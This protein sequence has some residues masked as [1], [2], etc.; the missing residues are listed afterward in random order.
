[1]I[2]FA[3]PTS[4]HDL[5]NDSPILNIFFILVWG[6]YYCATTPKFVIVFHRFNGRGCCFSLYETTKKHIN[7][8]N[9]FVQTTFHSECEV[10]D[11]DSIHI[12]HVNQIT[13]A[14][15]D[16]RNVKPSTF[17]KDGCS[18]Q[19]S[20]LQTDVWC[21]SDPFPNITPI[22]YHQFTI[23]EMK[24]IPGICI[25][26]DWSDID[27]YIGA[28]K[29]RQMS[30]TKTTIVCCLPRLFRIYLGNFE[31]SFIQV[32]TSSHNFP[33]QLVAPMMI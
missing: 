25:A 2:G 23:P 21:S 33:T 7:N 12:T 13:G 28:P 4:L 31:K 17:M 20:G 19:K 18:F 14:R 24:K 22:P 29:I 32:C 9:T 5:A 10:V 26:P 30:D 8:T 16:E 1:M 11:V 27:N 6:L 15:L 3:R